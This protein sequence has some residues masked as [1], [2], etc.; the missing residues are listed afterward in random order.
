MNTNTR[1]LVFGATSAICQAL[2]RLYAAEAA[3]LFL[4]GR[5]RDKLAATADD[6][7]VRGAAVH[8]TKAYDFNDWKQHEQCIREAR[9]GL[10][11]IDLIIIAHGTLPDQ[12]DCETSAAVTRDCLEDNFLSAAIILQQS[13][14]LLNEQQRGTI[15]ILSSVAGDRGRKSNYTYGAA[16]AGL[17]TLAQGM[18]GRFHGTDIEVV[19]IKPGMIETPM[20]DGMRKGLLWSTPEKIAPAI[21][22]AIARGRPVCYVPGYWRLIMFIIRTMPGSLLARLPI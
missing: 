12:H 18:R 3:N 10:G 7:K 14:E 6:L 22:R 15:A 21:K 13:G 17:D 1:I 2:L 20:T 9:N 16:K 19:T 8:G 5:D 4:A 11:G